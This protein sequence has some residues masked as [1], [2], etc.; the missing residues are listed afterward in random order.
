MLAKP[1]RQWLGVPFPT[2]NALVLVLGMFTTWISGSYCTIATPR[3]M[4]CDAAAQCVSDGHR[5][6]QGKHYAQAM[7]LFDNAAQLYSDLGTWPE[8]GQCKY[9]AGLCARLQGNHRVAAYHHRHAALVLANALGPDQVFTPTLLHEAGNDYY[10]ADLLREAT[11]MYETALD[12][13][14]EGANGVSGSNISTC[15][16]LAV[17]YR[18]MGDPGLALEYN[19]VA[20]ILLQRVEQQQDWFTIK[21]GVQRTNLLAD[22]GQY[23]A[24]HLSAKD[25]LQFI[26]RHHGS[27]PHPYAYAALGNVYSQEAKYDSARIAFEVARRHHQRERGDQAAH[28][29]V[30]LSIATSYTRSGNASQAL[31]YYQK[32]ADEIRL[33]PET[34]SH[35]HRIHRMVGQADALLSLGHH[36]DARQLYAQVITATD[37]LGKTG[38]PEP[39]AYKNAFLAHLGMATAGKMEASPATCTGS[40]AQAWSASVSLLQSMRDWQYHLDGS[41]S[42]LLLHARFRSAV[43]I[44]LETAWL[45]WQSNPSTAEL[46][47]MWAV[48]STTKSVLLNERC[49]RRMVLALLPATGSRIDAALMES[50]SYGMPLDSIPKDPKKLTHYLKQRRNSS[51][52]HSRLCTRMIAL[53]A[54]MNATQMVPD[55]RRLPSGTGVVEFFCSDSVGYTYFADHSGVHI[56]AFPLDTLASRISKWNAALQ[57]SSF[58][59]RYLRGLQAYT[60]AAHSLYRLLLGPIHSRLNGLHTLIVIPDGQLWQ[61][62]LGILVY[63]PLPTHAR[64]FRAVPYL[65]HKLNICYAFSSEILMR[66]LMQSSLKPQAPVLA[67][68]P[69]TSDAPPPF[70]PLPH[71]LRE[72]EVAVMAMGG[73]LLKGKSATLHNILA[74]QARARIVH[75]ATHSASD[76]LDPSRAF[77]VVQG[78]QRQAAACRLEARHIYNLNLQTDLVV[79]ASCNSG[80]GKFQVGEGVMD[81]GRAVAFS[82]AKSC[83]VSYWRTNDYATQQ[84]MTLFYQLLKRGASRAHALRHAQRTFLTQI[85]DPISSHPSLW[86]NFALIGDPRPLTWSN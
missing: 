48:L 59:T 9:Y 2:M 66:Q 37:S 46:M 10:L 38:K 68:A 40:T 1:V 33:H 3:A 56:H 77:L 74:H 39:E 55:V 34:P 49:L 35:R 16:N 84:V 58:R 72:A 50:I 69:C 42:K 14:L 28:V 70:P 6:L 78:H 47:S 21:V 20:A 4:A 41:S 22:F 25:L 29:D 13:A 60:E 36:H 53:S 12:H 81:L 63:K 71:S 54:S 23:A 52:A 76:T 17:I 82:G 27:P 64:D 31:K 32:V 73:T 62:P 83:I 57:D 61:V 75:F 79:L 8:Y 30:L 7:Q 65:L 67:V 24:A 43:D 11:L 18:A 86:G 44:A 26:E 51:K 19:R 45:Q 85:A 15:L 5:E 80:A